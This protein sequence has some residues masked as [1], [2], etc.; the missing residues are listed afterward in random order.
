MAAVPVGRFKVTYRVF[1][2]SQKQA[3]T[4]AEGIALEQTVEIPRDVVP[5]GF[6]EDTI[7]GQVATVTP[8]GEGVFDAVISYSPQSTGTELPQL[9]N[10][11]M[12]NTSIQKGVKTV[13][14][15]LGPL[16]SAHPGARFGIEGLRRLAG[17]PRGPLLSPVL[18]PQGSS[19][20]TLAD[21]AY[22]CAVGGAHL[23]KEDHG[24]TD[25]PCAPF[26]E[27][28]QRIGEAVAKANQETGR[29]TLYFAGLAG[30]S[31]DLIENARFAKE[32]GAHGLL[33]MPGLFGFDLVRRIARDD[34]LAL[35]VMTHPS[36]LGPYVLSKDTG[37]THAMMFGT[38]QRI[39]GSDISVF[40]NVGGR[41]GFTA[42]EC[43]SI[44]DACR[45]GSAPG[46]GIFPSPGGGMSVERAT[47][48]IDMYGEDA[49]FLL[50]GNLLRYGDNIGEGLAELHRAIDNSL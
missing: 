18:K 46:P 11:V 21:I 50:G 43:L 24:L 28:V 17:A 42:D 29:T 3:E 35:P 32:N 9:L 5:A 33:I 14:L 41:F 44:A 13:S 10:V 45:D 38:L 19:A 48:M 22:R 31:E 34:R 39:A 2:D 23:V 40:P 49:V 4:R 8:L 26:R 20:Q 1:A 16:K 30:H 47:D 7:M 36:F 15:D 25:Q 12:G 6:V 27:R 37:L